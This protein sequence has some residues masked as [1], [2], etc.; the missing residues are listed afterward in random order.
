M[1]RTALISTYDVNA[2]NKSKPFYF[3]RQICTSICPLHFSL[4]LSLTQHT[5][6]HALTH[7]HTLPQGSDPAI[8][9]SQD[10]MLSEKPNPQP[11]NARE[12]AHATN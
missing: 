3:N 7:S 9:V 10:T 2:T 6:G 8:Y 1:I 11:D 12:E 4:S 5:H